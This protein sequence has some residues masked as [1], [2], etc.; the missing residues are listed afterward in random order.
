MAKKSL[1]QMIIT[2]AD[3]GI[4]FSVDADQV[5]NDLGGDWRDRVK[6]AAGVG[7]EDVPFVFFKD[8][9]VEA[10]FVGPLDE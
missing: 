1:L 9:R 3:T 10:Q 5:D 7:E 6:A 8:G 2:A 4:G